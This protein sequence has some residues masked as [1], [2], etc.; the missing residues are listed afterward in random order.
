[1]TAVDNASYDQFFDAF[2]EFSFPKS[3]SSGNLTTG[4]RSPKPPMRQNDNALSEFF[5]AVE[6]ASFPL[7]PSSDSLV[8][9]SSRPSMASSSGFPSQENLDETLFQVVQNLIVTNSNSQAHLSQ[10]TDKDDGRNGSKAATNKTNPM[11]PAMLMQLLEAYN[12]FMLNPS[13]EEN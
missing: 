13:E 12:D 5:R 3:E 4:A 11:L 2:E 1:M 8:S 9:L 10:L 6:K 7:M